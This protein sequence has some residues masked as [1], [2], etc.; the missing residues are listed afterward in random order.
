MSSVTNCY[1][2]KFKE[3]NYILPISFSFLLF[4]GH[5]INQ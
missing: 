5:D 1:L 4:I 3:Q 2:N